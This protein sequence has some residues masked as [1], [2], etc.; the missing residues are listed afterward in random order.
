MSTALSVSMDTEKSVLAYTEEV[1]V[2]GQNEVQFFFFRVQ[3]NKIHIFF[4]LKLYNS[5]LVVNLHII[6]FFPCL[7]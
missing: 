7:I 4:P 5:L 3:T 1:A 2:R 6:F